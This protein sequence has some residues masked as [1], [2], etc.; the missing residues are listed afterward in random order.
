MK[1]EIIRVDPLASYFGEVQGAHFNHHP[2]RG[3][4]LPQGGSA[5][6]P[7]TGEICVGRIEARQ[8]SCWNS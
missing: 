7:D 5:F 3:P 2:A 8:S 6:E 1:K 4:D